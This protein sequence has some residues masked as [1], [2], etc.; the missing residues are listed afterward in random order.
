[1]QYLLLFIFLITGCAS[2]FEMLPP[3]SLNNTTCITDG[4]TYAYSISVLSV[5]DLEGVADSHIKVTCPSVLKFMNYKI[6]GRQSLIIPKKEIPTN[7][8]TQ[9][10]CCLPF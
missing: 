9:E 4:N 2:P 10:V 8:L 1:M 5:Y 6:D 7:P 3:P